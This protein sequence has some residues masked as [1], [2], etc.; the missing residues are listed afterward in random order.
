MCINNAHFS[1]L[2]GMIL[3]NSFII[4][5]LLICWRGLLCTAQLHHSKIPLEKKAGTFHIPWRDLG[6]ELITHINNSIFF[7]LFFAWWWTSSFHSGWAVFTQQYQSALI[8]PFFFFFFS[9]WLM[10]KLLIQKS[11]LIIG[12]FVLQW[13]KNPQRPT[14][15]CKYSLKIEPNLL[16][17][18]G[19]LEGFTHQPL[20]PNLCSRV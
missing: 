13:L 3:H 2:G 16:F 1:F 14:M 5:V 8:I 9:S 17:L 20:P 6:V 12:R 7:I 19:A 11:V 15:C 18:Q 4:Y 10:G